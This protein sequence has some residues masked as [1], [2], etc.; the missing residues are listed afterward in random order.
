MVR[1]HLLDRTCRSSAPILREAAV[2]VH[3]AGVG[4]GEDGGGALV[5]GDEL[6]LGVLA[7][8]GELLE[9]DGVEVE[10]GDVAGV[11]GADDLDRVE[12]WRT[13]WIT[14]SSGKQYHILASLSLIV[15]EIDA[16]VGE[17]R[18]L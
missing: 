18:L 3:V 5:Q 1:A 11:D 9:A 13:G 16:L 14:L 6:D 17:R 10:A 7:E 15:H 12:A 2:D 8:G 4:G